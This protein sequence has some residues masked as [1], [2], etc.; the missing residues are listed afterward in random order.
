MIRVGFEGD[1][2][3]CTR[4][5]ECG[6]H[7]CTWEKCRR[8]AE[9]SATDRAAVQ[10]EAWGGRDRR[11]SNNMREETKSFLVLP[12]SLV[13]LDPMFVIFRRLQVAFR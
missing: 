5:L 13:K 3:L 12:C 2:L 10:G 11:Q 9:D 8:I 4:V 7:I 1:A 6:A